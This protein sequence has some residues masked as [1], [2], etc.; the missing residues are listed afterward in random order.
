[1]S[2]LF[3]RVIELFIYPPG[4]LLGFVLLA[5][6]FRRKARL[7]LS[8]GIFQL[9][10]FSLPIVSESLIHSLESQH[11]PQAKLWEKQ[12]IPEAIVVLGGGRNQRAWEYGGESV[13]IAELER[14]RYAATLHRETGVPILV[15]GGDPLGHGVS[16][17]ELM[18]DT[19]QREFNVPVR[20]LE[21]N[22]HTTAQNAQLS[23]KILSESGVKS[24]WV[25]THAWHMPRSL[26][27][28][29]GLKVNYT[30]ASHSYGIAVSS[31]DNGM[32]WIP[33]AKALVRSNVAFHEWL[34]IVWYHFNH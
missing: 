33:Q 21:E 11:P 2:V 17:A 32:Q 1:M 23:D 12:A 24:A 14:L 7:I 3:K 6:V 20:W 31:Q 8:V 28:F 26:K 34:G 22:S 15:T 4:N 16:E 9:L 5:L 10:L 25:V 27:A 30:P 13:S 18:R 19:L 29:E